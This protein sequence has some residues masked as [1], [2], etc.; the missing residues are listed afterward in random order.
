MR[1]TYAVWRRSPAALVD[2][3]CLERSLAAYRYLSRWGAGPH[4]ISGVARDGEKMRG[5][6]WVTVDGEPLGEASNELA[7]YVPVIAFGDNG[8]EIWRAG[9]SRPAERAP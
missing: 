8:R 9:T 3:N 4:L 1:L 7:Q 6:V 5:H 2:G